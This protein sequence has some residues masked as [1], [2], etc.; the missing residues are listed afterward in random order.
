[1]DPDETSLTGE[2]LSGSTLFD[3]EA[4]KTSQQMLS[5]LT[6]LQGLYVVINN[7][8]IVINDRKVVFFYTYYHHW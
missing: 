7:F 8:L 5:I 2:V 3:Q 4:F 1:M 6:L